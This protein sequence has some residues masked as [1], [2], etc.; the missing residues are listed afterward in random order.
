[1]LSDLVRNFKKYFTRCVG[2]SESMTSDAV[3][4]GRRW[5]QRQRRAAVCFSQQRLA[6]IEASTIKDRKNSGPSL[7]WRP[8]RSGHVAN[9]RSEEKTPCFF[10]NQ[11]DSAQSSFHRSYVAFNEPLKPTPGPQK[12]NGWH[13]IVDNLHDSLLFDRLCSNL[14]GW[15]VD[16]TISV[17]QLFST[18]TGTLRIA[19]D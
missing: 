8:H 5:H 3:R 2:G 4:I 16:K 18:L 12:N 7:Q 9:V 10:L 11:P 17:F 6:I 1:M 13:K 15:F 14:W 19:V